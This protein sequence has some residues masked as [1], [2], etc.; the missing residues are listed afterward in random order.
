MAYPLSDCFIGNFPIT[1]DFGANPQA[2]D[3][4][5]GIKGHNGI[6][7]GCPTNTP[8][9]SSADGIVART[10]FDAGGYGK[11]VTINHDGYATLYAHLN[12]Y[13]VKPGDKVVAGQ[14]IGHSN[15][16]GNS[17]GPHLHFGV[18]PIDSQGNKTLAD[19]GYSGYI[20][21]MGNDCVWT[22]KNLTAPVVPDVVTKP[23][24]PVPSDE[25]TTI[26]SQGSNYKTIANFG[27]ANG[28]NEFLTANQMSP[29][30]FTSNPGDPEGGKKI[31]AYIGDLLTQIRE[32]KDTNTKNVQAMNTDNTQSASITS[33]PD[34]TAQIVLTDSQRQSL[35]K[36]LINSIHDFIFVK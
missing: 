15:N 23:D 26:V 17:T 14:L 21:P 1:Q 18:K 2:Y 25:F 16:T 8:V 29:I 30:D 24:I 13:I 6:D 19:N 12:D 10:D 31:N 7:F 20:D 3:A 36:G 34:G 28:L 4:R 32:L 5:Y 22:V 11:F 35:F 27:I 9:V 33:T